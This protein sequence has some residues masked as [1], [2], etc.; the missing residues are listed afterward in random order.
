MSRSAGFMLIE[1]MVVL[2][3]LGILLAIIVPDY[4]QY[5]R[6]GYRL[7][8]RQELYRLAAEQQQFHLQHRRYTAALSQLAAPADSYLTASGRFQIRAMLTA[9]GY[10]L[11]AEAVGPQRGDAPC[12]QLSLNQHNQHSSS[13]SDECW[14]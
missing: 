1:V 5:L 4:Q 12:Q 6:Q 2:A 9:Q 3:V 7:E 10:Q 8:A 11:Q 14:R 13:P